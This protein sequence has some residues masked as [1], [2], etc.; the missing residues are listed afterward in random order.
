MGPLVAE[1]LRRASALTALNVLQLVPPSPRLPCLLTCL[2]TTCGS[3]L[4]DVHGCEYA[5][6]L[7]LWQPPS[8]EAA[9]HPLRC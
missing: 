3:A 2:I 7:C 6:Q 5:R 4:A 9:A 1:M 8:M